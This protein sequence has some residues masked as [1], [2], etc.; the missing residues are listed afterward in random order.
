LF[1][2]H[3]IEKP[4]VDP[5]LDADLDPTEDPRD[6]GGSIERWYC[7]RDE[8]RCKWRAAGWPARAM[9]ALER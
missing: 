2:R 5:H 4:P 9:R 6:A 1:L 7:A 3:T 8:V